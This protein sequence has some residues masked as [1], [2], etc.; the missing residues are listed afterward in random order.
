MNDPVNHPAH[1]TMGKIEVIDAIEDWSL[2]YHRGQV[3]KYVSRAGRK[4][5]ADELL[6]LCKAQW[7]LNREIER[8]RVARGS[9]K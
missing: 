2:G 8:L 3:I 1:Y 7:Y 4:T 6:D 9:Q 5:G